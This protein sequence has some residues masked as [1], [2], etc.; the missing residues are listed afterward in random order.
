MVT[1]KSIDAK[2]YY[3][4]DIGTSTVL[5]ELGRGSM[6]VVFEGYQRTLKRKIALKILPRALMTNTAAERFQQEAEAA[7]IL[8]HPNII[9][10]YEVGETDEF[11]FMSM[12]LVQGQDLLAYITRAKKNIIPSKRVLPL[13]P[14]FN[15]VIRV[16]EAL[17]YAHGQG[18]VHRDIK[19]PNILIEKHTRRPLISDFGTARFVRGDE[20]GKELILGTPLYMAPEQ[21]ATTEVDGRADIYAVGVMLFQMVVEKLP[22]VRYPSM[23][24]LLAH[25]RKDPKGIFLKKPSQLNGHLHESLD[26]II[27][28][29]MA[30]D[31]EKRF[32]KCSELIRALKWYRKNH[33]QGQESSARQAK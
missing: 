14:T 29:A 1:I 27:D 26:R 12:Q 17:D 16:L 7:A 15:V 4:M 21:I 25:K 30:Y 18:I 33:L 13:V 9:P 31:P 20:S 19:P 28:K 24:A 6:A 10:I 8:S 23:M 2:K 32:S 5:K 3:G 11:L 22:F